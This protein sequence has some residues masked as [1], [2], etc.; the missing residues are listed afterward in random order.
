MKTEMKMQSASTAESLPEIRVGFR[1]KPLSEVKPQRGA[2]HVFKRVIDIVGA[3]LALVLLSPVLAII[4]VM[5][6]LES[7][8][9]IIFQQTRVGIDGRHFMFYKFRTMFNGADK[10]KE[11]LNHLNEA[12]GPIFKIREDPRVTRIGR[13]L[14]KSSLDELPQLINVLKGEMS[15]VGP[16]PPVPEEV[17]EYTEK[18][19]KRLA[20]RPGMTCLWQ[21][22]GRSDLTFEDQVYLDCLYIENQSV[23]LDL[24]LICLTIPVVLSGKGAY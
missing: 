15:L 2:Y 13:W 24:G 23:L 3:L 17:E 6:K 7:P 20:V 9:S 21:V 14:R 22:L 18:E 1:A 4:A 11:G 12:S 8:G 19:M 10:Q 16:R 5:I